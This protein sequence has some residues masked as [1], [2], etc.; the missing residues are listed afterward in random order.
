MGC[1]PCSEHAQVARRSA[2]YSLV[3]DLWWQKRTELHQKDAFKGG[4]GGTVITK[5]FKGPLAPLLKRAERP[6]PTNGP[7]SMDMHVSMDMDEH[8]HGPTHAHTWACDV[9]M[10][11]LHVGMGCTW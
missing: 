3:S 6:L 8:Q 10:H 2:Y 5:Y 9:C 1:P 11:T 4:V 7:P